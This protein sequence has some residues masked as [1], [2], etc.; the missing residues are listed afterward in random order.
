MKYLIAFGSNK[1]KRLEF[2]KNAKLELE[3]IGEVIR[4]SSVY[5]NPPMG[6]SAQNKFLNALCEMETDLSPLR[7]LRK[8]KIIE[9]KLGR[10]RSFHWG[11][12]EI[13]LDIID[14]SGKAV[15]N[16]LLKIPHPGMEER[17]FVLLPL[18]EIKENYQSRSGKSINTLCGFFPDSKL[19]LI[20]RE[21]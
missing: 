15:N 10:Q 17:D 21:W 20:S 1:G 5:E 14:W 19:K 6:D 3:N 2:I 18:K 12:R 4:Y 11:P 16:P 8:L 9:T 7:L 13:D